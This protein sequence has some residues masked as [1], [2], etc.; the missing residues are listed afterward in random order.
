[1]LDQQLHAWA[2]GQGKD[3]AAVQANM[4]MLPQCADEADAVAKQ[5]PYPDKPLVDISIENEITGYAELQSQLLALAS[6][7][8][9]GTAVTSSSLTGPTAW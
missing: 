4:H 6:K 7:S 9:L 8:L 3:Q 1:M 5:H 2:A